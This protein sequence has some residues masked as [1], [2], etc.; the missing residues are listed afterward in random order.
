MKRLG[1]ILLSPKHGVNPAIPLCFFCNKPKNEIM[2]PGRWDGDDRQSPQHS[3]WDKR[4]CDRCASVMKLGIILISVDEKKTGDNTD[5]PYRTGG[6]IVLKEKAVRRMGIQPPELEAEILRA[7]VCF[8]P[9]EVWDAFGLPRGKVDGVPD[10]PDNDEPV[11][12]P[13][14]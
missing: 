2:L 8:M 3:V 12:M 10:L 11:A 5:N 13:K 4:P 7:R 1:D 14:T 9:D 6:W